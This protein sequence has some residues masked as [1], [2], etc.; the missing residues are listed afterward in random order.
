MSLSPEFAKAYVTLL[1]QKIHFLNSRIGT[2]AEGESA[3]KLLR[4]LGEI[5]GE[6]TEFTLPCS[7]SRAAESLGIGRASLYRVFDLLTKEGVLKRNGKAIFILKP[8][9]IFK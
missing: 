6:Q 7:I 4:W 5:S 2:F 8:E 3:E 9:R 1:S